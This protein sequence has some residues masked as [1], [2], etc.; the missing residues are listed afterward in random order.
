[1]SKTG[2]KPCGDVAFVVEEQ[3]QGIGIATYLYEMLVTLARE[4]GLQ[5]FTADV[6]ASNKAMMKVFE[7]GRYPVRATLSEG[8]YELVI[9]F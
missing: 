1:M 2:K 5:G 6:L 7:K 9:T 3:Y 8:A 4:R